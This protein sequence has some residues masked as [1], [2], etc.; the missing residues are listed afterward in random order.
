MNYKEKVYDI[1]KWYFEHVEK[2]GEKEKEIDRNLQN[3]IIGA[4]A[5][6]SAKRE[7]DMKRKAGYEATVA[8]IEKTRS[9]Q[10]SAVDKWNEL[11]ASKLSADAEL[12]KLDIPMTQVQFQQ[13]CNKHADNSLM[14]ALL[15][16]YAD[17]HKSEALYA[18]RPADAETRKRD[19]SDYCDRAI[20]VCR[21]PSSISAALFL[22]NHSVPKSITYSYEC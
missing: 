13:L 7:L 15:C 20:G 3:D 4:A 2:I 6:E 19:F 10:S 5:A 1:V 17:K 9:A 14:L 8:E 11:D 18:D 21:N 12:L 22:D 16:D